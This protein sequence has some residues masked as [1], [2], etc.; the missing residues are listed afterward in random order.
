MNINMT[1]AIVLAARSTISKYTHYL[2][3]KREQEEK[4]KQDKKQKTEA[5]AIQELT[6]RR[7]CL[8]TDISSLLSNS[9]EL[10]EKCENAE[11]LTFV[12]YQE[13]TLVT[14]HSLQYASPL[15]MADFYP[16]DTMLA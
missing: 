5:E 16:H 12:I 15:F 6:D 8:K 11:N 7:K 2:T 10:Y 3:Q 13:T 1:H 9:K 14:T 4:K